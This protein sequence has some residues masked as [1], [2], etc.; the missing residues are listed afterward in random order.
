MSRQEGALCDYCH[1]AL[2]ESHL[3][4]QSSLHCNGSADEVDHLILLQDQLVLLL[5]VPHPLLSLLPGA[6]AEGGCLQPLLLPAALLSTQFHGSFLQ[7]QVPLRHLLVSTAREGERAEQ[8]NLWTLN[9][10][11]LCTMC[12][13]CFS[14]PLACSI[15]S[16]SPPVPCRRPFCNL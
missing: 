5:L 16:S 12:L 2:N 4:C 9:Q 14:S 10:V 1:E 8:L 15:C 3:F 11:A 7:F 13:P 6:E